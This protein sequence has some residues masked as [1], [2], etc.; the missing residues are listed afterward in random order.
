MNMVP[1]KSLLKEMKADY[2][3]LERMI[4]NRVDYLVKEK[5]RQFEDAKGARAAK[6]PFFTTR[7]TQIGTR[8]HP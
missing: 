5:E 2:L 8:T 1:L 7:I 6:N 4:N 3:P